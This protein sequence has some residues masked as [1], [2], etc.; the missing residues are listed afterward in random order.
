[1]VHVPVKPDTAVKVGDDG[2]GNAPEL[3]NNMKIWSPDGRAAVVVN[4]T[5]HDDETP[6]AVVVGQNV[7]LETIEAPAGSVKLNAKSRATV[8]RAPRKERTSLV[9]SRCSFT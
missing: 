8:A 7:T 1:V 6:A 2:I 4:P 9:I 5:S 3:G